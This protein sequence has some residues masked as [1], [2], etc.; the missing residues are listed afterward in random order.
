MTTI[1]NIEKRISVP[2]WEDEGDSKESGNG[3]YRWATIKRA[4]TEAIQIKGTAE[5][6][7]RQ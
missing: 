6:E 3:G 4:E 5:G 2:Q 7:W 1:K